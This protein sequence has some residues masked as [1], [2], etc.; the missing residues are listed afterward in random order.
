VPILDA[1]RLDQAARGVLDYRIRVNDGDRVRG[2]VHQRLKDSLGLN[3]AGDVE[4]GKDIAERARRRLDGAE[5]KVV[6]AHGAPVTRVFDN[7]MHRLVVQY[8]AVEEGHN[9]VDV[10]ALHVGEVPP[11]KLAPASGAGQPRQGVVSQ[12]QLEVPVE[13]RHFHGNGGHQGIED[14]FLGIQFG[15]VGDEKNLADQASVAG[16]VGGAD[17]KPL[18]LVGSVPIQG[19][20]LV[21]VLAAVQ[22]GHPLANQQHQHRV[23]ENGK[24]RLA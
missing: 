5:V 14:F 11:Q 10:D 21:D 16:D 7:L 17:V 22:L 18:I 12:D 23:G 3:L 2:G 9:H 8:D 4:L 19:E 24:D 6:P 15:D 20:N 1:D 13:H